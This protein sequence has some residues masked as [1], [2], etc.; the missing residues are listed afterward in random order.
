MAVEV[1]EG[2]EIQKAINQRKPKSVALRIVLVLIAVA[3]IAIGYFIPTPEGLSE[4]GKM[5]IAIMVAGMVLWVTEPVPIAVSGMAL[6]VLLPL[7]NVSPFLNVTDQATGATTIGV[8]GNFISNVIFFVLASFGITAAL[9]KTK[10]PTK[11]VLSLMR[12][13]KGSAKSTILVFMLATALMSSFVSNL[14]IIALFAGVAMSSIVELEQAQGDTKESRNLGKAM[15][16]GIAYAGVMGGMITPAGSAL[17]IMTL[18]ML[19]AATASSATGAI[20][21]AFLQWAAIC[22]PIAIALVFISWLGVIAVFRVKRISDATL[23]SLEQKSVTIGRLEVFD[24]KVIVIFGLMIAAWI[25][26][27]WTG[28]DATMIALL[29]LAAFFLPGVDVLNWKEYVASVN[30]SVMLLTGCVQSIAGGIRDQ[31]AAAWM[32]NSSLGKLTASAGVITFAAA[33][34]LPL[35]HLVVPVG[36][37]IIAISIF[38]LAGMAPALGV[39]AVTF[40]I[41]IA[42]NANASFLLGLDSANMMTYKY[43]QW[44]MKDFFIAGIIPTIAMVLIHTFCLNPLVALMGF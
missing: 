39:S 10:V 16:I 34:I 40:A 2:A 20:N 3:I 19:R 9:L 13:T 1:K 28:W 23:E 42:F 36:P 30:W 15:M 37:A 32:F 33:A 18:N 43:N 6:M 7:F 24:Y 26:S 29:G 11:I 21:V 12:L 41:I 22:A 38:P 35:I 25:A 5:A 44:T 17:N 8:W 27:N 14:P 4:G 31:G